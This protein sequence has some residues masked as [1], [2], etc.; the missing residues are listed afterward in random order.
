MVRPNRGP[1]AVLARAAVAPRAGHA[2]RATISAPGGCAR[3]GPEQTVADCLR[4]RTARCGGASGTPLAR[5]VLNTPPEEGSARLLWAALRESFAQ[6]RRRL[7]AADRARQPGGEPDRSGAARPRRA[8]RARS[9]SGSGCGRV[10]RAGRPRAEPRLRPAPDRA[11][12]R[13]IRS[14]LALP[15]GQT[16]ALLPEIPV[17]A[18]RATRSSTA[19]SAWR[20]PVRLPGGAPLLGLVGGTAEWLFVRDELVSLT[21]SAADALA[22]RAERGDRRAAVGRYR[23]RRWACRRAPQP[24]ARIVKERRATFAQTPAAAARRPRPATAWRQP[25]ARRR[26][27]RDRAAGDDRGRGAL[28]PA[29]GRPRGGQAGL[30]EESVTYQP[31][32]GLAFCRPAGADLTS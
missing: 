27:D 7:P 26:L 28:G 11:R 9:R 20:A 5:A 12:R 18:R 24:P 14:I 8:R 1:A 32:A 16:G 31:H 4:H 23:A 17:P 6:R 19:T 2:A 13:A 3:A 10:E 29:R 25:A 21:V 15:P 22:E 30:P